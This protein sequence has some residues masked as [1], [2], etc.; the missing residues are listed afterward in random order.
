MDGLGVTRGGFVLEEILARRRCGPR[1]LRAGRQ[2]LPVT[3]AVA[4]AR[5]GYGV[6]LFERGRFAESETELLSAYEAARSTGARL[7]RIVVRHVIPHLTSVLLVAVTLRFSTALL[8]EAVLSYLGLGVPPPQATLGNM[9]LEGQRFLEAALWLSLGP[10]AAILLTVLGA[11][12]VG[13]GL[14]DLLDPR[15]R[16]SVGRET[17]P[18]A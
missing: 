4:V 16:G 2:R 18:A 3:M 6:Y 15:L 10:G 12:M 17:T 5:G 9:I 7:S 11:N 13:D 14:R 1:G 8:T